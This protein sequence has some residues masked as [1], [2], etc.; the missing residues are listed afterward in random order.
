MFPE[1]KSRE[2]KT[3]SQEANSFKSNLIIKQ[4]T[5]A[6]FKVAPRVGKFSN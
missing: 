6:Q 2:I 4:H 5:Q 1:T 3:V